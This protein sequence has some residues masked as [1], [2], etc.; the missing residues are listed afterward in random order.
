[1]PVK[2][3]VLV[4]EELRLGLRR[5]KL[6]NVVRVL[7]RLY[8]LA[9]SIVVATHDE[10]VTRNVA[11][12]RELALEEETGVEVL[13]LAIEDVAGENEKARLLGNA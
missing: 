3:D 13:P 7:K 11:E 4:R 9:R 2:C 12:A 5:P 8:E 6:V 10:H 1:M